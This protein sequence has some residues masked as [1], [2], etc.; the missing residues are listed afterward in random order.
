MKFSK[1]IAVLLSGVMTAAL[2]VG[3][4]AAILAASAEET[5]TESKYRLNFKNIVSNQID[6]VSYNIK[7]S[8]SGSDGGGF[9]VNDIVSQ[10]NVV[11]EADTVSSTADVKDGFYGIARLK[12]KNFLRWA[13]QGQPDGAVAL[14]TLGADNAANLFQTGKRTVVRYEVGKGPEITIGGEL[15][16]GGEKVPGFENDW[17]AA[18][19]KGAVY[20]GFSANGGIDYKGELTNFKYYDEETRLD[21]GICFS[22]DFD[23]NITRYGE[24]GKEITVMPVQ[25]GDSISVDKLQATDADGNGV[26]LTQRKNADGTI[27][28]TM[29]A[30][31]ITI[32]PELSY[33]DHYVLDFDDS[34]VCKLDNVFYIASFQFSGVG[35]IANKRGSDT[36]ITMSYRTELVTQ[37]VALYGYTRIKD[38]TDPWAYSGN[39]WFAV[40]GSTLNKV[41]RDTVI[42]YDVSGHAFDITM[43][44]EKVAWG[45]YQGESG[46]SC[47]EMDLKGADKIGLAW[48][49][50][51]YSA[52]LSNL[53]IMDAEQWDLG[54]DY[55]RSTLVSSSFI[56]ERYAESGKTV[57][58]K[59]AK[60]GS[61]LK[62]FNI[63]DEQGN[64]LD[65]EVTDNRD[66]TYSFVM[67][68]QNVKVSAV[69]YL[70]SIEDY[71]GSYYNAETEK[72]LSV[73]ENSFLL[74]D[75][76]KEEM[77]VTIDNLG[78]MTLAFADKEESAQISGD[79]IVYGGKE[80]QR[81]RSYVVSFE[82][83]GGTGTAEQ[84]RINSG[85]YLVVKPEDPVKEGYTFA[86]WKTS[87]GEAFDFGKPVTKSLTLIAQWTAVGDTSGDS[88][89]GGS[90]GGKKGCGS[91]Y[92]SALVG[93]IGAAGIALF[94]SK[95]RR[96]SE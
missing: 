54:F 53:R 67:P 76:R 19:E 92:S 62:T 5:E 36:D 71:Y 75:G 88:S 51:N 14:Y 80:Y 52:C 20:F 24:T 45:L 35:W 78:G 37:G 58:L 27:T 44:G 39:A 72:M 16:S 1:K 49:S 83:Q 28:F 57:T 34:T 82:L 11:M 86:G 32:S 6:N 66:G 55:T 95:G 17:S 12:D 69:Y 56:L 18:D 87:D 38:I 64:K 94:L 79:S 25:F 41:G 63:T 50:G 89:G 21:L 46:G 7:F 3:A 13:Y 81:L 2:S 90:T 70:P 85:D 77:T 29:P 26:I 31:D 10:N 60:S 74:A 43:G 8:I 61:D 84:Q 91:V 96:K 47:A 15:Q 23:A 4:G 73:G 68:E 65:V 22:Y 48:N 9:F 30:S 33:P 40:N 42:V 59:L 93:F